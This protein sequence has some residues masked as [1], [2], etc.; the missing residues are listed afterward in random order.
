MKKIFFYASLACILAAFSACN[1]EEKDVLPGAP[2]AIQGANANV[3]PDEIVE[4][5]ISVINE[6]TS[7][8]WYK[9]GAQIVGATTT[10]YTVTESGTYTVAGVNSA[11]TGTPSSSHVVT[12]NQCD[13]LLLGTWGM[14]F[15]KMYGIETPLSEIG[16]VSWTFIFNADGTMSMH[17]VY[18]DGESGSGDGTYVHLGDTLTMTVY[19]DTEACKIVLLTANRLE[20][21]PL[22]DPSMTMVLTKI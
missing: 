19:G 10:T 7:Y 20:L 8:Q 15:I 18:Q 17:V 13:D 11:G 22:E 14:I 9:N 4:L 2:G 5:T 16:L 1:N 21:T 3:C 6:A 12:I